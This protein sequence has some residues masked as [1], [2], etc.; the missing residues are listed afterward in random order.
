VTP[1]QP[2]GP[3]R[4]ADHGVFEE[5]AVGYALH[6]LEPEDELRFTAHL[7]SCAACDRMLVEHAET[8]SQLAYAAPAEEPPASLL[9]GISAAVRAGEG[10]RSSPAGQQVAASPAGV[11]DLAAARRRRDD[12]VTVPRTWLLSGAAA[13]TALVLGLGGLSAVLYT[14]RND[15][16]VRSDRLASTVEALETRDARAVQLADYEGRVQAVVIAHGQQMSLVVD[17]LARNPEDTVYVLWGQS[18]S[19]DVRALSTFDV[20]ADGLD[21]HHGMPL[22]VPV[23][24]LTTL[25]VTHE[26]T[27]TPPEVTQEQ[28]LVAGSV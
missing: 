5:L 9:A 20:T 2:S 27:R 17:G 3:R 18:R 23:D 1:R 22:Q 11:G 24:E 21:V 13:V 8:L 4:S 6:A 7:S 14:E 10:A 26:K 28:V 16:T 15:L 12:A 19:G 25:M